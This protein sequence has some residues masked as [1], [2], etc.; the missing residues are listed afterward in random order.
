MPQKKQRK[1]PT[2]G[3]RFS[4]VQEMEK[5]EKHMKSR[6]IK[7]LKEFIDISVDLYE[8]TE[9]PLDTLTKEIGY[10]RTQ[11][12]FVE[13]KQD[14]TAEAAIQTLK[15]L[16]DYRNMEGKDSNDE[17]SIKA[18][19][20]AIEEVIGRVVSNIQMGN[21]WAENV[22]QPFGIGQK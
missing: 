2:K 21:A 19:D 12:K 8:R 13:K 11:L 6:N 20:E 18:A 7:S 5:F 15:Q 3:V 10:L 14:I 17:E 1:Y 16:I 9:S 4:S 22:L